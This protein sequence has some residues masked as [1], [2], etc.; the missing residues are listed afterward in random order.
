MYILRRSQQNMIAFPLLN[1]AG[2]EIVGLG[3]AFTVQISKAGGAFNA[4]VGTKAE[5]G[6]G[7]YRYVATGAE[8][9]TVGPL[10][11]VITAAGAIQQNLEY[12]IEER[13]VYGIEFTY[14]VLDNVAN[15]VQGAEVWISSDVAGNNIVWI[16]TTDAFGV[17][18][19]LA[20]RLPRLDAGT[21]YFW[22]HKVGYSFSNPDTEVVS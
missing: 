3:T 21:W 9:D 10:V 12:I 14:T 13:T 6:A 15:P 8:C 19:D 16:G 22:T 17:A 7:I 4:G 1:A 2:T 5:I 18:R 20:N 11:I